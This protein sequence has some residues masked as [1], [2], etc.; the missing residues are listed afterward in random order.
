[1]LKMEMPGRRKS[2]RPQIQRFMDVV[3]KNVQRFVVTEED[4]IG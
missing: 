3:K 1:M 2:E 4:G